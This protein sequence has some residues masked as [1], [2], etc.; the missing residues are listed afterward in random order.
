MY[1]EKSPKLIMIIE[2]YAKIVPATVSKGAMLVSS[3]KLL[4]F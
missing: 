2:K 3:K 1:L 4:K